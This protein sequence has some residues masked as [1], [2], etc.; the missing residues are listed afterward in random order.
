MSIT[1][2]VRKNV[3]LGTWQGIIKY[4]IEMKKEFGFVETADMY[5]MA[6]MVWITVGVG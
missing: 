5:I 2:R 4:F 1:V 6:K 3:E